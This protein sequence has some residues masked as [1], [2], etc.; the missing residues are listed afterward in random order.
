M[1][2]RYYN[3]ILTLCYARQKVGSTEGG[4]C[5]KLNVGCIYLLIIYW[6]IDAM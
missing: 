4:Y 6:E 5:V 3:W 2:E 1:K